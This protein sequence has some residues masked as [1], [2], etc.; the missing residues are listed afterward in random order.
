MLRAA[1]PV[2]LVPSIVRPQNAP[3]SGHELAS[4]DL[5]ENTALHR[6]QLAQ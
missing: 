3:H 4:L 6:L 2:A 1:T 5:T